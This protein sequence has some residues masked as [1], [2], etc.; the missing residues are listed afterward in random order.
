MS[1]PLPIPVHCFL[2]GV[3]AVNKAALAIDVKLRLDGLRQSFQQ[4]LLDGAVTVERE[5][6][7]LHVCRVQSSYV[8][9]CPHLIEVINVAVCKSG[10]SPTPAASFIWMLRVVCASMI[11]SLP[12]SPTRW[13]SGP[14][15]MCV[16]APLPM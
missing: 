13:N 5:A 10:H 15:V 12:S 1:E 6:H 14:C 3:I 7:G 11:A 4:S 2:S 8:A 9:R 16:F